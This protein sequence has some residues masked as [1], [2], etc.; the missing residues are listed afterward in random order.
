MSKEEFEWYIDTDT[1]FFENQLWPASIIDSPKPLEDKAWRNYV[2]SSCIRVIE[3]S[4][5]DELKAQC[6]KLAE[7]LE[8][9]DQPLCEL[10][11]DDCGF[12]AKYEDHVTLVDIVETNSKATEE[13]LDI[14]RQAIKEYRGE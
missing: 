5:Y 7:A 2:L 10:I 13:I 14:V 8:K 6:E 3:K 4:A 11:I 12:E 9:I 1:D